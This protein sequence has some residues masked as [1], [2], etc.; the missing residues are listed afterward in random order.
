M[1]QTLEN[2]TLRGMGTTVEGSG[3]VTPGTKTGFPIYT[4]NNQAHGSVYACE[5]A[6]LRYCFF[7]FQK[8]LWE[9]MIKFSEKNFLKTKSY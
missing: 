3:S 1:G 5:H 4:P 6:C 7:L 9:I 2:G 8:C